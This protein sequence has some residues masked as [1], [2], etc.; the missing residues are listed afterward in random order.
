M[1]LENPRYFMHD[2][3][4]VCLICCLISMISCSFWAIRPADPRQYPGSDTPQTLP[5]KTATPGLPSNLFIDFTE[6][7]ELGGP[8]SLIRMVF[9][10]V[11][12]LGIGGLP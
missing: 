9:H 3:V 11:V 12:F 5:W 6:S 8:T 7:A 1:N 4:L 10:P 2:P